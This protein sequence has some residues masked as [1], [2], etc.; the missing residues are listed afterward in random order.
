MAT[1]KSSPTP[2]LTRAAEVTD[3]ARRVVGKGVR[4]LAEQGGPEVHQVLAYDLAH[5]AAA[6]ETARSLI[7]YGGKGTTEA[8]IT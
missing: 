4:T 3:L 2:D 6:I 1:S 8:L 7:D 5:S